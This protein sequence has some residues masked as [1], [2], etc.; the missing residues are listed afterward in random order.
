[1]PQPSITSKQGVKYESRRGSSCDDHP[2]SR[3]GWNRWGW[4]K[5]GKGSL[6]QPVFLRLRLTAVEARGIDMQAQ[7]Q[8]A[9]KPGRLYFM[10]EMTSG[11]WSVGAP[12]HGTGGA[13]GHVHSRTYVHTD[14]SRSRRKGVELEMKIA[15]VSGGGRR[16]NDS[17]GRRGVS[18][19]GRGR[20]WV[21]VQASKKIRGEPRRRCRRRRRRR[22]RR[23]HRYTRILVHTPAAC[24]P[25]PE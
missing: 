21:C 7:G 24:A 10:L 19:W 3:R 20:G 5:R 4:R 25:T 6:V 2:R 11:R 23:R 9:E 1:M 18:G 14:D 8:E 15:S 16:M 17:E 22:R 12:A 13:S